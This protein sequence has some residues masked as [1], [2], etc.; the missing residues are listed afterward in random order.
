[1]KESWEQPGVLDAFF[2]QPGPVTVWAWKSEKLRPHSLSKPELWRPQLI[3][4]RRSNQ[5]PW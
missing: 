3:H 1:M 2:T 5:D 4:G